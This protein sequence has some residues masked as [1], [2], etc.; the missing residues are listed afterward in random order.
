VVDNGRRS[1]TAED[2]YAYD[3]IQTVAYATPIIQNP[4][5][6]KAHP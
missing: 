6:H 2:N 3:A 5:L 1:V 4:A